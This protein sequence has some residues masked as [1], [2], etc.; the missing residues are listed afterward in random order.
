LSR[1]E[2]RHLDRI[3]NK[4]IAE[5]N[6]R[7]KTKRTSARQTAA[8]VDGHRRVQSIEPGASPAKKDRQFHVR[9]QDEL[10]RDK[11]DTFAAL[12]S[13]MGD[14]F[15]SAFDFSE[16]KIFPTAAD[17]ATMKKVMRIMNAFFMLMGKDQMKMC[18][19]EKDATKQD[20]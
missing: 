10:C 6:Q 20:D 11:G 15:S 3:A 16:G 4:P 13:L 17:A 8:A 7:R 2:G 18:E 9:L 14:S 5:K 1:G 12:E 19:E